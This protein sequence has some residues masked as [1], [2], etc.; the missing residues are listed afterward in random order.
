MQK[1]LQHAGFSSSEANIY[2]ALLKSGSCTVT[3]LTQETGI[4]RTYIYDI[5]EKLREKGFV[6]IFKE[7]NKKYFKASPP[8]RVKEYLMEKI[9]TVDKILPNLEKLANINQNDA[10]VEVFKGIE[11]LKTVLNEIT[12]ERKDYIV[13]G[14]VKQFEFVG[15]LYSKQF[16]NKVN[17]LKI[18]EKAILEKGEKII[19][20][21]NHEYRYLLKE[22]MVSTSF[23]LFGEKT[24]LLIWKPLIQ[25][26]INNPDIQKTYKTQFNL[27]WKIAKS[28]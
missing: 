3:I 20:A 2:L 18:K 8:S 15:S 27:L 7:N 25:I 23:V 1:E 17:K 6:S 24:V 13:F 28:H 22:H 14:A 19:Q 10:T 11:G 12:R 16:L 4:H 9:D 26:V 5:L 21:K